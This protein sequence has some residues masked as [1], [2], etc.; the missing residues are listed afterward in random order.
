MDIELLQPD[1]EVMFF[2]F[3]PDMEAWNKMALKFSGYGVD[4]FSVYDVDACVAN[5]GRFKVEFF[6][7][8][9]SVT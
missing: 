5:G 6:K 3:S 4:D 7:W 2:Q 8:I 1:M 9:Q